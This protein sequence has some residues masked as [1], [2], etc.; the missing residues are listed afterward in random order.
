MGTGAV[1]GGGV[2]GEGNRPVLT[3]KIRC[4]DIVEKRG[5]GGGGGGEGGHSYVHTILILSVL[6]AN[7]KGSI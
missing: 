4:I 7:N 5:G 6:Y 3:L 1:R 2:V